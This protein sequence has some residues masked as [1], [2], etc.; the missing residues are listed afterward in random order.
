MIVFAD[1]QLLA[2]MGSL[3]DY[4]KTAIPIEAA[5]LDTIPLG[6]LPTKLPP[7]IA[8]LRQPGYGL[9]NIN[10]WPNGIDPQPATFEQRWSVALSTTEPMALVE[11]PDKESARADYNER[12]PRPPGNAGGPPGK[13][14]ANFPVRSDV[15]DNG[16]KP[17]QLSDALLYLAAFHGR[18]ITREAL[19]SGLP[20]EHDRLSVSLFERAARRAGLEIVSVKRALGDIPALVLPAVLLLQDES[21]RILTEIDAH[22]K[23]LTVIDPTTREQTHVVASALEPDYLGYAFFVGRPFTQSERTRVAGEI[24][25]SHWF[26]GVVRRFWVNYSHVAIAAFIVNVLA[27]AAPLFMM[28]VYD[29]VVPNGAIPLPYRARHRAWHRHCLRFYPAHR[30]AAHHRYDRQETRRCVG[31]RWVTDMEY[32]AAQFDRAHAVRGNESDGS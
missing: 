15:V 7:I 27:L 2:A 10:G 9:S 26:W 28:N 13:L 32:K 19:L 23:K 16:R 17:D 1:Y 30:Q 24:P 29:R 4:L 8:G 3:L 22:T 5:P 6:V 31:L 25:R 12:A 11:V 20:I 21:A 18:A 14:M